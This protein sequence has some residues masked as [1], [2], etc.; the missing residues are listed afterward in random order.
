MSADAAATPAPAADWPALARLYADYASA[1]DSGHWDL[2]PE[3]FTDDCVYRLVPRETL[4]A[5]RPD[6]EDGDLTGA[7]DGA[8][9]A[10]DAYGNMTGERSRPDLLDPFGERPAAPRSRR[11]RPR[12][13]AGG[14]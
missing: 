12:L 3:F 1:V 14:G 8:S 11:A 9:V 5:M 10:G 7:E 6:A 4:Y 13:W 2:W